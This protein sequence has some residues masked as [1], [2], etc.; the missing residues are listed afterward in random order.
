MAEL[1]IEPIVTTFVKHNFSFRAI[2][3]HQQRFGQRLQNGT[4]VGVSIIGHSG[5]NITV[6]RCRIAE[7]N[8]LIP[9][10]GDGDAAVRSKA[11]FC[12]QCHQRGIRR[13]K[14]CIGIL[15]CQAGTG[16]GG[17]RLYINRGNPDCICR[18]M[19][20]RHGIP[21]TRQIENVIDDPAIKRYVIRTVIHGHI[22]ECVGKH[23]FFSGNGCEGISIDLRISALQEYFIAPV[24]SSCIHTGCQGNRTVGLINAGVLVECPASEGFS[25]KQGI[26]CQSTG[27]TIQVTCRIHT[28]IHRNRYIFCRLPFEITYRCRGDDIIKNNSFSSI[29]A[30]NADGCIGAVQR[31]I[32][33]NIGLRRINHRNR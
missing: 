24:G 20:G 18:Y 27:K 15:R 29:I 33:E 16:S 10:K 31:D 22:A 9:H 6:A 21:I 5:H 14:G 19:R 25:F 4:I 30:K 2:G 3:N 23:R 13:C 8:N 28:G 26:V 11:F 7:G 17:G 32:I 12:R 1:P